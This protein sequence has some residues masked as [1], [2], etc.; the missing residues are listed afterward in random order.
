V[1]LDNWNAVPHHPKENG[2]LIYSYTDYRIR[3]YAELETELSEP[4]GSIK[5]SMDCLQD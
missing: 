1:G 2:V 5:C 3:N 4:P